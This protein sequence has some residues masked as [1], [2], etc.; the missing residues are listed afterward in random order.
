MKDELYLHLNGFLITDNRRKT[1]GETNRRKTRYLKGFC[2]HYK[3]VMG[4]GVVS[5]YP[6]VTHNEIYNVFQLLTRR[7]FDKYEF[8]FFFKLD[9]RFSTML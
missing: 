2:S 1:T 9:N 7:K 4:A 3:L 5:L 6:D 8:F